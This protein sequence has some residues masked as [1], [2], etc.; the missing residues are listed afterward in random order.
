MKDTIETEALE[1]ILKEDLAIMD[2]FVEEIIEKFGEVGTPEKLLKK[3]YEEWTPEDFQQVLAIYG[4]EYT[5]EFIAKK[6]VPLMYE[7][8]KEA[9]GG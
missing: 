6:E 9:L 7:A 8:E 5:E 4:P 2:E 1:E 3:K